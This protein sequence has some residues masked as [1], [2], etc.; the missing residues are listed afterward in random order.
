MTD[1]NLAMY[2]SD[3]DILI[4]PQVGTLKITTEFGK[5]TVAPWEI[6]VIQ[7]G[8]KFSVDI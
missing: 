6:C 7:R 5:M 3:G 4:V 8:I 1:K 2:S